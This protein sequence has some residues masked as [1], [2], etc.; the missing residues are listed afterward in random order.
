MELAPL[1]L[2]VLLAWGVCLWHAYSYGSLGRLVLRQT[3]GRDCSSP[4]PAVSIIIPV[5]DHCTYLRDSL[6]LLLCQDYEAPFEVI[7]VDEQSS[8]ETL[9]LLEEL[10]MAYPHLQHTLCPASARDISMRRLSLTLGVRLAQYEWIIFLQAGCRPADAHWLS[11]FAAP[12]DEQSDAVLGL[13]ILEPSDR[14]NVRGMQFHRLWHQMMWLPSR[15]RTAPFHGDPSCLAYRRSLFFQHQGFASSALLTSGAEALLLNHNVMPSRCAVS[16]A[17]GALLQQDA[18]DPRVWVRERTYFVETRHHMRHQSVARLR[19]AARLMAAPLFLLSGALLCWLSWPQ[20]QV[21]AVVA[22]LWFLLALV[23]QLSFRLTTAAL[24]LPSYLFSLPI[25]RHRIP[26]QD[27]A[28]W[29][30]WRTTDK[31][32]FRRKFV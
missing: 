28:S 19:Y 21:I 22:V 14:W 29:L 1:Y 31:R 17:R 3:A 10:E 30:R 18:P 12:L 7:V 2:I 20:W 23:R 4:R 11:T 26:R 24:G 27:F 25:L 8:D 6:P 13:S 15:Q 16:A 5:H 9:T 32:A